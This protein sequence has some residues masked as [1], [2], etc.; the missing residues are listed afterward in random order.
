M[1]RKIDVA[2]IVPALQAMVDAGGTLLV[3]TV[4]EGREITKTPPNDV[5][6]A[7]I[8]CFTESDGSYNIVGVVKEKHEI[9]AAVGNIVIGIAQGKYPT[10]TN[11]LKIVEDEDE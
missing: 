8:N 4:G 11:T 10:K 1:K 6:H 3:V 7:S 9:E 2:S 5:W